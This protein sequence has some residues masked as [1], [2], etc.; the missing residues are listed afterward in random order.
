MSKPSEKVFKI[1]K[2]FGFAVKVYDETG[3]ESYDPA[4]GVRFFV[5]KPNLMVTTLDNEIRL[6]KSNDVEL[7][8][9][10]LLTKQLKNIAREY[11]MRYNLKV[12]GK[13]ITPKDFSFEAKIKRDKTMEGSFMKTINE[14]F[15]GKLFGRIKTS[16]QTLGEVKIIYKHKVAV[17]ED[18][19]SSRI[20]N[21]KSITLEHAGVKY[22]YPCV[23]VDGARAMARHMTEGGL[24]GDLAGTQILET[25][26]KHKKLLEFVKYARKNKLVSESNANVYRLIEKKI[27]DIKADL[28]EFVSSKDYEAQRTK[29]EE[30][31]LNELQSDRV[32]Q[33][34]DDF[35][36]KHFDEQL[37]DILPVIN[38]ILQEKEDYENSLMEEIGKGLYINRA[39]NVPSALTFESSQAKFAYY[40]EEAASCLENTIVSAFLRQISEKLN[41][42][43][44]LEDFEISALKEAFSKMSRVA[45]EDLPTPSVVEQFEDRIDDIAE[46]RYNLPDK[47]TDDFN[48][49]VKFEVNGHNIEIMYSGTQE[50]AIAGEPDSW[51]APGWSEVCWRGP[52]QSMSVSIQADGHMVVEDYVLLDGEELS[53]FIRDR[54]S[55]ADSAS[56]L[57]IDIEDDREGLE[58]PVYVDQG[59]WEAVLAAFVSTKE[60]RNIEEGGFDPTVD[61]REP[62]DPDDYDR[63][64]SIESEEAPITEIHSPEVPP[65]DDLSKHIAELEQT[66]GRKLTPEEMELFVDDDVVDDKLGFEMPGDDL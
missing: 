10:E 35:T 58:D 66:L 45:R 40:L 51:D 65:E 36:V 59:F 9:I 12:Y 30:T 17:N 24:F 47:G 7:K 16:Y 26:Q 8:D 28:R 48:G 23:H 53:N 27:K 4:K 14:A 50:V 42:N 34:K 2:G 55:R 38:N 46:A 62:P 32:A 19:P 13:A 22:A 41:C 15:L 49:S 57:V 64:E 43:E 6:N 33:L 29:F 18:V 39:F 5:E 1:L 20:R 61:D 25:S 52:V 11:M 56:Q 3:N 60:V 37:E 54:K 44:D 31:R 21:I 63:Y